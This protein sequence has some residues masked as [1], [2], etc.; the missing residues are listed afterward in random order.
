MLEFDIKI[1]ASDLYDYNLKYAFSKP[2]NIICEIFGILG[3]FYGIATQYWALVLVGALL[4]IYL[5]VTLFFR[6]KTAA[7][8]SVFKEPLHYKLDD[9][10][11]TISKGEIETSQKWSDMVRAVSTS[12][13]ILVFTTENAATIFPRNQLD[14]KEALL[15]QFI[16]THMDA[17]RVRIKA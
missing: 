1:G 13:S 4:V 12:R 3:L 6:S 11:L 14:G 9:E 17:S 5:P 8:Q 15:I 10:A 2:A 16:S 7:M